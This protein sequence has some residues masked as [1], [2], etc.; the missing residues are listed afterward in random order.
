METKE[1]IVIL[2][3]YTDLDDFYTDM[4]QAGHH[5]YAPNRAV[6]LV[7]RRPTSRST[8]YQLTDEEVQI[9]RQDPRVLDIHRPYYDLGYEIKSCVSQSSDL[10][11]KSGVIDQTSQN[12][13]NWGLL[14]GYLGSAVANWGSDGNKKASGTINL[15][16]TGQ[17]VDIIINDTP[18]VQS[19]PEFAVNADG[20]G[21]TRFKNFNWFQYNQAVRGVPASAYSYDWRTVRQG[22]G[23]VVAVIESHGSHV[24]GIAAGNTCGWSRNANIYNITPAFGTANANLVDDPNYGYNMI[25]YIREF[26]RNKSIN[27][28]TGRRNP[29]IVNMSWGITKDGKF[30]QVDQITYKGQVFNKSS[31]PP[32]WTIDNILSVGMSKVGGYVDNN[33]NLIE[34]IFEH[35]VRDNSYDQ[36]LLDAIADGII[37][38]ASAGN[39]G[40][41][42]DLPSSDMYDNSYQYRPTINGIVQNTATT[43]YYH[44]GQTPCAALGVICVGNVDSTVLERKTDSS[45]AGPR[46]DIYAAGQNIMSAKASSSPQ[47][48][49]SRNNN[50]YKGFFNGTSMSAPQVTGIIACALETYPNMTPT[51]ALSYIQNYSNHGVLRDTPLNTTYTPGASNFGD[52]RTLFNGPNKYATYQPNT[53]PNQV[54]PAIGH[55]SRPATGRVYPRTRIKRT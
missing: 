8:H 29:T 51:Q 11:D 24:A 40:S 32:G 30:S 47:L 28:A 13:L 20:T 52:G 26:H 14:R 1:Y 33:G 19:H 10:W 34:G 44:R 16:N 9:L 41:Y 37:V 25:N 22:N 55:E 5:E 2:H 54:Y 15:P 49:D 12:S 21:G 3:S 43:I 53:R 45:N 39:A 6:D 48:A 38:V 42:M 23:S 18:I 50:Y 31:A 7:H 17:N 46:V 36:D 35:P 4:E 27:E